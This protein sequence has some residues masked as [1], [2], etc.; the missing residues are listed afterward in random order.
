MYGSS[1]E[2]YAIENISSILYDWEP[3]FYRTA[4]GNEIDLILTKG[5]KK[6]A[7]ECKATTSPSLTKGTYEA[8]KDTGIDELF[9][10]APVSTTFNMQRNVI[11]GNVLHAIDYAKSK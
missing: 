6:I 10:V 3:W 7:F 4:T 9:I 11:V 1:W 2:G 5:L 8:L